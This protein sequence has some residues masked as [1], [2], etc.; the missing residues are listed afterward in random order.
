MDGLKVR[1]RRLE[2][3]AAIETDMRER[4]SLEGEAVFLS[5]FVGSN[6][7]NLIVEEEPC[8]R[9]LGIGLSRSVVGT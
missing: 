4:I 8:R 2:R 9:I 1:I 5:Q 3:R 6:M 7:V